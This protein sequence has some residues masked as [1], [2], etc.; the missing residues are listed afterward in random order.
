MKE[1]I[2]ERP[3]TWRLLISS[4]LI[5]CAAAGLV[6]ADDLSFSL[7]DAIGYGGT[8]ADEQ[9]TLLVRFVEGDGPPASCPDLFGP[10]TARNVREHVAAG[11]VE[12]A[13]VERQYDDIVG[14]LSLV[15]L[16]KGTSVL[17]ALA[18][19]SGCADVLYA[20]PNYQYS[21]CRTPNDELYAEQWALNNTGQTGGREDADI[22]APEAWDVQTGN[23]AIIVAILDTGID[24]SHPDLVVNLWMNNAEMFGE[25]D[26]DDDDNGYADDFYGYDF[27]NGAPDPVDD[28]YH[29][30]YVAGIIGAFTNNMMGMAGVCWN[31]S[32]MP[33][34]VGDAEGVNLDAAIAAIEY[35]TKSGAKV[36]N[37]SWAGPDYSQSLKNAID[38]AGEQGIMF[39]AAAGNDLSNNDEIPMY[40]ASYESYNIISVL[41]TDSSDRLSRFSNYGR[42]SVD[43]GEPGEDVLSTLPTEETAAMAEAGLPTEYGVLS[44]TSV[45]GPHVAAACAL[46]WSEY[47]PLSYYHVKHALMQTTDKVLGGLCLSQGRLNLARALKAI[48][49]GQP[50][51]VL[52]T[53]DDPNDPANFYFSIQ[54]AIDDANDGDVIVVEG[55]ADSNRIYLERIDFKGK[56]ITLRS[57]SVTEPEDPA[58][59][60]ET[61]F[62]LG[63]AEEGPIVTFADD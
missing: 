6:A 43:L 32:L 42:A 12:G 1:Q 7:S 61:T 38:A 48:P 5:L 58:I 17:D 16:P 20:E 59:Y 46:M 45:A 19:F 49:K 36:I 22:D 8:S 18:Q 44:G 29:G 51:R 13:C 39:V 35:A 55:G 62:L 41:A 28:V 14:G 9:G 10:R 26:V 50:G 47:P 4:V 31:V 3:G 24:T 2:Q 23:K 30:T 53:R 56:A 52:N 37:A 33:L 27:V 57:G 54:T 15:S 60:P 34:K 11:A 40:P 25:A 21:L 63:L